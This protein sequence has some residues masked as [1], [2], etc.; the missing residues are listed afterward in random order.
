MKSVHFISKLLLPKENIRFLLIIKYRFSCKSQRICG[1][2]SGLN[3]NDPML[4]KTNDLDKIRRQ[5]NSFSS[6]ELN[7]LRLRFQNPQNLIDLVINDYIAVDKSKIPIILI[8]SLLNG[9]L[10][11]CVFNFKIK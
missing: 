2:V 1:G 10:F 8:E 9:I 7:N 5:I 11:L 4:L 3:T 6:E